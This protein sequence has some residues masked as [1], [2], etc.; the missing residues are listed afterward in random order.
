MISLPAEAQ[1]TVALIDAGGPFPYD[2][3]G[4]VFANHGGCSRPNRP[5]TT[6]STPA[7]DAGLTRPPRRTPHHHRQR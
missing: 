2:Q 7:Y 1:Q 4:S 3:D 5:V 6:T